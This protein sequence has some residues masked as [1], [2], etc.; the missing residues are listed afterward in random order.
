MQQFTFTEAFDT[1]I[2]HQKAIAW[3]FQ[4]Q[5]RVK[6]PNGYFAFP[7]GYY[8]LFENGY[9]LIVSGES[10]EATPIQEAQILDP[11]GVPIARDTEDL[12]PFEF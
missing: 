6:L 1:F 10:L 5:T 12:K 11:Q 4:Q 3:G 7:C 2:L 9:K 8:T